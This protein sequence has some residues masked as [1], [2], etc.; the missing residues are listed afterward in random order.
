[1]RS[2]FV[3]GTDTDVGKTF[4]SSLLTCRW[5]ANYWKPLQTG[6]E[7]DTGDTQT[8]KTLQGVDGFP[9]VYELLKPLAPWRAAVL[10]GTE[11]D[12]NR[13]LSRHRELVGGSTK[14][15]I[16]E[17]A[18]GLMVPITQDYMMVDLIRDLKVPVVLVARSGLGTINHTLLSI[19]M[20]SQYK[21]PILCVVMSGELNEDNAAV[22]ER[23]G[24][25]KVV[26][27]G[28]VEAPHQVD[29]ELV[30]IPPLDSLVGGC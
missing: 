18:G 28:Q 19:S 25:V 27:V 6:L 29:A 14:D 15:L 16:I 9:P 22:I 8:I 21:I 3:T 24:K 2:I 20:L 23:V 12:Y 26:Q 17:G 11:V 7:S 5:N 10:E 13:V 1:M 4:I 30:K